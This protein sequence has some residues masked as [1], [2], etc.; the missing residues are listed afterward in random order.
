MKK[1]ELINF[2]TEANELF[3]KYNIRID[4]CGCC[5]SPW[6]EKINYNEDENKYI[7]DNI[8]IPCDIDN[9][10]PYILEEYFNNIEEDN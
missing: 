6:L 5:G 10:L 7:C 3:E 4:G 9:E 2:L 8:H 1:Q